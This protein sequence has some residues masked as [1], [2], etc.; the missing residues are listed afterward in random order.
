[1]WSR[2][3]YIEVQVGA[4]SNLYNFKMICLIYIFF[5]CNITTYI[6]LIFFANSQKG[7]ALSH[8]LATRATNLKHKKKHWFCPHQ[9]PFT[10]SLLTDHF[11]QHSCISLL[12]VVNEKLRGQ[13]CVLHVS[14]FS[15]DSG[16][17]HWP[18]FLP[19]TNIAPIKHVLATLLTMNDKDNG[20][21]K[22]HCLPP[23]AMRFISVASSKKTSE[24]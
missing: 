5:C 4:T 1:V 9:P 22:T 11:A 10:T 7:F 24:F 19:K 20:M 8:P 2:L 16:I 17:I 13:Q 15:S 3:L 21:R 12:H 14:V 6:T 18:I 23:A